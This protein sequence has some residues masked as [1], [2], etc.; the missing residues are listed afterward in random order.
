M[1]ISKTDK[2]QISISG[3]KGTRPRLAVLHVL[4][5]EQRP[6]DVSEIMT[7]LKEHQIDADQATVYRI[8]DSF[9][10]KGL[11]YRLDFQERK[12]RY[13][14]AAGP[15]HHHLICEACG[16][17]EDISDCKITELQ[18]AISEK[19]GFAIKRHSLEFF[20]LC[21]ECQI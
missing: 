15:E 14:K 17:I 16:R 6:L 11:I 1:Q 2:S 8:V 3:L 19:K 9:Y 7:G 12:F 5:E 4:E 13:E 20:G 21:K 18:G 10:K